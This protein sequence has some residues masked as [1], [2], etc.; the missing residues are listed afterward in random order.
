[1][2]LTLYQCDHEKNSCC[3]KTSC[4]W[5]KNGCACCFM[6]H[7]VKFA[8]RDENNNPIIKEVIEREGDK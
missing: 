3:E 5:L 7:E 8:A 2:K 4:G 6:T 1:M